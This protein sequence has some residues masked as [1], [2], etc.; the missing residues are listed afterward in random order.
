MDEEVRWLQA[1]QQGDPQAITWLIERYQQPVYGLC[2]RL[3]EDAQEAEDVAQET[4][5]KALTALRSYD[6]Q[7]PFRPWLLRIASN[8][9]IDRLR[10][11]RGELSLDGMDEACDS[12]EW[13]AGAD[14][15]PEQEL[16]AHELRQALHRGMR[17]LAAEDAVLLKLFYWM[18]YSYEEIAAL[19]GL[20]IPALKS[21][22]FRARRVLAQRLQE[23]GYV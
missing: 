15:S 17:T 13:M 4:F 14:P 10:R 20:T 11:R 2:Y 6:P 18:N 8:A 7:R 1:A 21:R 19:T 12:W 23:E 22:L 16:E 3:L 9:C 5:I